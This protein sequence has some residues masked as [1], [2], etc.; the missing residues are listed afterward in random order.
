MA[1]RRFG[2]FKR[3]R[4]EAGPDAAVDPG[5]ERAD[6]A[7]ENPE[8]DEWQA[9]G[10]PPG[11]GESEAVFDHGTEEFAPPAKLASGP[12]AAPE[13]P[14]GPEADA[15]GEEDAP[16]EKPERTSTNGGAGGA[17]T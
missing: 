10:E 4:G 14:A 8:T 9:S 3:D 11:T 6:E 13:R 1:R 5:D 16:A 15:E 12:A 17:D 7:E 2:I